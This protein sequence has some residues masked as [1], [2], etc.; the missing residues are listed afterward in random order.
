MPFSFKQFHID[1]SQCGMPVSTDGVILGAW[2][3]LSQAR[4]IIDIGA[5]SGLLS[6]MAAQRSLARITAIEI[7]AMAANACRLNA[8]NSPWPERIDVIEQDVCQLAALTQW[9]AAADFIICNPPYF[10]SGPQS[11]KPGRSQARHTDSLSFTQLLNAMTALMQPQA[12][13]ALILPEAS[14][15]NFL[16]AL[17][18][19]DL[20]VLR[21]QTVQTVA[22]KPVSRHLLAL[23]FEASAN[24]A[25]QAKPL[26]PLLIRTSSH[27]YSDEMRALTADFYLGF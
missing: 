6:I 4:H 24:T 14:L 17:N 2:A 13:A 1:D 20:Q 11:Q 25:S 23:G 21:H 3:E 5:G 7:D 16:A 22:H 15:S 10:G 27:D 18:N 8:A 26:A 12:Q 9:Q 19:S